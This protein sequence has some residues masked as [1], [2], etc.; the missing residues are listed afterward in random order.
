MIN[1]SNVRCKV[2][3]AS[4]QGRGGTV[5]QHIPSIKSKSSYPKA[6]I[7]CVG[8]T[9]IFAGCAHWSFINNKIEA[10]CPT[11]K[12]MNIFLLALVTSELPS[13]E[14][15]SAGWESP[16]ASHLFP[17]QLLIFWTLPEINLCENE[18][19][20]VRIECFSVFN[21]LFL[22]F[23]LLWFIDFL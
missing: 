3:I 17:V 15:A 20:C 9:F 16:R 4:S 8:A 6:A 7:S 19:I 22:G 18:S 5:G 12:V 11:Q 14:G 10:R 21:Q 23:L 2:I 13:R 1:K